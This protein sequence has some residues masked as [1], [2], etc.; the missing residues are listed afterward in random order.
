MQLDAKIEVSR[1][2]IEGHD[3]IFKENR[4][5]VRGLESRVEKLTDAIQGAHEKNE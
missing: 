5:K 4:N 1:Q 3:E 2:I